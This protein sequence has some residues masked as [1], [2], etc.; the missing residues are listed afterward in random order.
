ML[1]GTALHTDDFLPSDKAKHGESSAPG[2]EFPSALLESDFADL[3]ASG[4]SDP[5][6]NQHRPR[7]SQYRTTARKSGRPGYRR[8]VTM[9]DTQYS[10]SNQNAPDAAFHAAI[11]ASA[12]S[13]LPAVD[14]LPPPPSVVPHADLFYPQEGSLFASDNQEAA[15]DQTSTFPDAFQDLTPQVAVVPP[16]RL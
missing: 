7:Y 10:D 13:E 5:Q 3:E 1:Q 4:V 11:H 16:P 6:L 2:G 8:V 9:E 14:H 15:E 12:E